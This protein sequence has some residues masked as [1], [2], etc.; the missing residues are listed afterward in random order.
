[1]ATAEETARAR[2]AAPAGPRPLP[3]AP[4]QAPPPSTPAKRTSEKSSRIRTNEEAFSPSPAQRKRIAGKLA[5]KFGRFSALAELD[6]DAEVDAVLGVDSDSST[7]WNDIIEDEEREAE[8]AG[9]NRP[10]TSGSSDLDSGAE[11]DTE[12]R[13]P[14]VVTSQ[15]APTAN[16]PARA[17]AATT[18]RATKRREK[19]ASGAATASRASPRLA[20]STSATAETAVSS[21]TTAVATTP[22]ARP[23]QATAAAAEG[24]AAAAARE[25]TISTRGPPLA[26]GDTDMDDAQRAGADSTKSALS[27]A[28]ADLEE[29]AE[30][31]RKAAFERTKAYA[32]LYAHLKKM[33]ADGHMDGSSLAA[34]L[35]TSKACYRREEASGYAPPFPQPVL[36][37]YEEYV[38]KD[39]L[40]SLQQQQQQ[41]QQQ[42]HQLQQQH[43]HQQQRLQQHTQQVGQQPPRQQQYNP[44]LPGGASYSAV[45][46]RNGGLLA[47]ASPPFAH[48]RSRRIVGQGDGSAMAAAL[49][50][51]R[52]V[53]RLI[54]RME[55]DAE[56]RKKDPVVLVRN[57]ND[58][59]AAAGA[60]AHIRVDVVSPCPSG[61]TLLPRR[62]CTVTQLSDYRT[63][64]ARALGAHTVDDNEQW[65][66]WVIHSVVTHA[67]SGQIDEEYLGK[68]LDECL[69][70]VRRGDV[71]RLCKREEDW[72]MKESTPV[73][74][75]T[76]TTA[77]LVEGATIRLLGRI[78]RLRRYRVRPDSIMCGSC[79]SYRHRTTDCRSEARCRRCAK[80][81]H[82]EA[83]HDSHC[84][85]CKTGTPCVPLC[86]HCRGPHSAGDKSCRNR[87]TWD[88][89]AKAY[90]LAGGAELN[91]IN[92]QGDRARGHLIRAAAGPASGGNTEPLGTRPAPPAPQL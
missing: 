84:D 65:E 28:K 15:G 16:A 5:A 30:K 8:A 24:L 14:G 45:A 37:V 76:T 86:M 54:A 52:S 42:R 87:P 49:Q 83:S 23:P 43:Q 47:A 6:F 78:F 77:G 55:S 20:L 59:L 92:A 58:A 41:Q 89:F 11:G 53:D 73:S 27:H 38:P 69:P 88:R 71:K 56:T 7:S 66:R 29:A 68:E 50:G 34:M 21:A 57:V 12:R 70:G 36:R 85:K 4:L 79:G 62:G 22:T 74:F 90:T 40:R 31:Q 48:L 67:G 10:A 51:G 60:S 39:P 80:H 32:G 35:A 17:T 46:T 44:A 75:F 82:D 33:C 61:L 19:T 9:L 2:A 3:T 72:S 81:G 1:M 13:E 63:A 64:I 26:N 18:K 91:R 25:V